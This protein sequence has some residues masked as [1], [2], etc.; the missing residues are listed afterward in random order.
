M[1]APRDSAR[2][3]ASLPGPRSARGVRRALAAIVADLADVHDRL[4]ALRAALPEVPEG[5]AEDG[6]KRDPRAELVGTIECVVHDNLEPAIR[7]LRSA[8]ALPA[9]VRVV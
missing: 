1:S 3:A 2:S 5:P 9:G 7:S 4:L 6:S 8:A